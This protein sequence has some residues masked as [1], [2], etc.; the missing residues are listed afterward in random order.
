MH[1]QK[2]R[3]IPQ[4]IS[5]KTQTHRLHTMKEFFKSILPWSIIALIIVCLL[6]DKRYSKKYGVPPA[7][8]AVSPAPTG[9]TPTTEAAVYHYHIFNAA[10]AVGTS[11][12]SWFT[13]KQN[14]GRWYLFVKGTAYNPASAEDANDILV[15]F[16]IVLL[17]GPPPETTLPSKLSKAGDAIGEVFKDFF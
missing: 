4:T 8:A 14:A 11:D 2:L 5:E 7:P 15:P 12:L 6:V 17:P 9:S 10:K 16:G 3:I 1:S 13:A